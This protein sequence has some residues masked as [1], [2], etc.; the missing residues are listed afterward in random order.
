MG[1]EW[2]HLGGA[3]QMGPDGKIYVAK[4]ENEYV[5]IIHNPNAAGVACGYVD[6]GISVYAQDALYRLCHFGLPNIVASTF[7]LPAFTYEGL[8]FSESTQ[9]RSSYTYG[10][11]SVRWQFGDPATGASNTSALFHPTH[12]FSKPGRYQVTFLAYRSGLAD[13]VTKE[14]TIKPLPVVELGRDTLLCARNELL[15]QVDVP[16][17]FLPLERRLNA[18]FPTGKRTRHVFD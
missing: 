9:F 11:D 18:V 1:W 7:K 8:C 17:G 13:T 5:G 15:L 10:V 6:K 3:L 12:L 2:E 16:G 14:V 4:V